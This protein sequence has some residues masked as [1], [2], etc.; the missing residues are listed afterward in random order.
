MILL[1]SVRILMKDI[2]GALSHFADVIGE[3]V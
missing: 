1:Q 2:L 3:H